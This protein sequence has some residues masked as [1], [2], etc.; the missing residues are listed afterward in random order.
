MYFFICLAIIVAI[1]AAIIV[2]IFFNPFKKPEE[3]KLIDYN[4]LIMPT[5]GLVE[6]LKG[7][8]NELY[9]S[10]IGGTR[11]S[12]G[13]LASNDEIKELANKLMAF[14]ERKNLI[15]TTKY[16]YINLLSNGSYGVYQSDKD[17]TPKFMNIPSPPV[18]G[19]FSAVFK[20][21]KK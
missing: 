12:S 9:K 18:D 13:Q 11:P 7:L 17:T 3:L 16:Y 4:K 2:F 14:M 10:E 8:E 20:L 6:K 5:D 15:D 21:D 19:V 1:I